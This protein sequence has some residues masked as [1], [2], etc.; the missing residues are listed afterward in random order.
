MALVLHVPHPH[1]TWPFPRRSGR[2]Y[3]EPLLRLEI[4]QFARLYD[5]VKSEEPPESDGGRPAELLPAID[6]QDSAKR[7]RPQ[8]PVDRVDGTPELQNGLQIERPR[9]ALHAGDF[10]ENGASLKQMPCCRPGSSR[11]PPEPHGPSLFGSSPITPWFIPLRRQRPP[12]PPQPPA[13]APKET[14][15]A[16]VPP[17]P[18]SYPLSRDPPIHHTS[19]AIPIAGTS[20]PQSRSRAPSLQSFSSS[21]ILKPPTSPLVRETRNDDF[22]PSSF[23]LS[24]SPSRS[25]RRHTFSPQS[26]QAVGS[27]FSRNFSTPAQ[28]ARQPPS[29]LRDGPF[30]LQ[31]HHPRRSLTSGIPYQAYSTPQTPLFPGSRRPSFSSEPSP[32]QH[33]SM[34]GSYEESILR[35][36]MST[37]PSKP[38]DFTAQ[39]GALGKGDCKPKHPAH[40]SVDF[41][42]VYYDWSNSLG[43]APA[44]DNE[45]SPYVGYIDLE[46]KLP[47]AQPK[48][49]RR[50]RASSPTS[51]Q[52]DASADAQSR[53]EMKLE[54]RRNHSPSPSQKVPVGGCYRIPQRGQLQILIKSPNK[55]AVK[56]FLLPYDLA[57]MEPGTKT[58]VR[59]RSYSSGPIIEKPISSKPASDSETGAKPTLK[60]KPSL[61]YLIQL[62]ICCLSRGRFYLYKSIQVVF[63]NRVPDNKENLKVDLLW[64]EPRYSPYKAKSEST[65]FGSGTS[66][67][68]LDENTRRRSYG[69]HQSTADSILPIHG[70]SLAGDGAATPGTPFVPPV[71]TIPFNFAGRQD[72]GSRIDSEALQLS[73]D[74][75]MSDPMSP[76]TDSQATRET[77]SSLPNDSR[78]DHR[79]A[80][81]HGGD[82]FS[83]LSRDDDRF[84]GVFGRPGTPEPGEGL[85]ARRLRGFELEAARKRADADADML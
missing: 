61:R 83:K 68:R 69:G 73:G 70:F 37:T 52:S 57:G 79:D 3:A 29:S 74:L 30:S 48:G 44:F 84:G 45:P 19:A 80:A 15:A 77:T 26:F 66:S 75:E 7:D 31:G 17:S 65:P 12:S 85:L 62:N 64:P 46:Q 38:L 27:G 11:K 23:D 6:L 59:Q 20:Q 60:D 28:V 42:A 9:S 56:L 53:R 16:P 78:T 55:T 25:H 82:I 21:F 34:V 47:P 51:R 14:Q 81:S 72:T 32:I 5:R 8:S 76:S 2:V 67:G 13:P 43:R 33:A 49:K 40:V 41:P 1:S 36:R 50:N 71:P 39:I 22:E 4:S 58:F 63:A 54:K 24:T 18:P 35:G 10:C